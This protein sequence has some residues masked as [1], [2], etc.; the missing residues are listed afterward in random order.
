MNTE[1]LGRCMFLAISVILL[2]IFS[3]CGSQS[4][5]AIPSATPSRWLVGQDSA[6]QKLPSYTFND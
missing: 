6:T 2:I 3:A 5:A 1:R 4:R